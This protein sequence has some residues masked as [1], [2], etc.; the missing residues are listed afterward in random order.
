MRGDQGDRGRLSEAGA[1]ARAEEGAGGKL[2]NLEPVLEGLRMAL[3][4]SDEELWLIKSSLTWRAIVRY[5]TA[6]ER[7]LPPETRRGRL[8]EHGRSAIRRLVGGGG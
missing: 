5:R 7:L 8:Y 6:R 4:R 2:D 1:V 3:R